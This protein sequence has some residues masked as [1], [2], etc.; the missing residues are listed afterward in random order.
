MRGRGKNRTIF[1]GSARV[2]LS[3][4]FGAL[5]CVVAA[6][7]LINLYTLASVERAT[8]RVSDR[9]RIRS[10]TYHITEICER[11]CAHQSKF[12]QTAA[13]EKEYIL[14]AEKDLAEIRASFKSVNALPLKLYEKRELYNLSVKVHGLADIIRVQV[15]TVRAQV[16]EGLRPKDEL[17]RLEAEAHEMLQEAKHDNDNLIRIMDVTT[18]G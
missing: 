11:M 6:A 4:G 13:G 8:Q 12:I 9:Q 17:K 18:D 7:L 2:R 1:M 5:L 3:A 14:R 15:V 16:L 10:Q